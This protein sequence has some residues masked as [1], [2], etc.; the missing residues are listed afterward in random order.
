MKKI[1]I[2][3]IPLML[4]L[5]A[6]RKY[7]NKQP[8]ASLQVPN[9]LAGYRSMLDL[10][11]NTQACT[12]GLGPIGTGDYTIAPA[13]QAG[14]E[15]ISL[16]LCTWQPSLYLGNN[17]LSWSLPYTV[18]YNCNV[19]LAGL[20]DLPGRAAF[21]AADWAEY[22]A[23]EGGAL[24]I[25]SLAF[26]YLEEAFGRPWTPEH[27][28]TDLGIPL[29]LGTDPLAIVPRSPVQ[30]VYD[31]IVA[32]LFTAA[33]LLPAALQDSNRN[34]PCRSAAY[35][36]LAK[37]WLSQQNPQMAKPAADSSLLFYHTLVDYNTVDSAAAHP[38]PRGGNA[39]VL[40]QAYAM[41]YDVQYARST[42]VDTNLYRS[43]DSDDLRKVVFFQRSGSG[44]FFKGGYT[45]L[46]YLFSGV[47][48][49]DVYLLR[50]ECNARNGDA[51]AAL[52]D[53]DTLLSYRW[54]KG[55]FQ[56]FTLTNT[57]TSQVLSLVLEHRRKE[58]L[59]REG[60]WEDLRRLNQDAATAD[61]LYRTIDHQTFV[62]YPGDARYTWLIPQA[63]IDLG[64]L[65][66]NPS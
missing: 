39:E 46:A 38:F 23:I 54:R 41:Y 63:E 1:L 22:N 15:P 18:I 35:G 47:G 8:D 51:A 11:A 13:A 48:V 36:L 55:K 57:R 14:L 34:R 30:A 58:T 17:N 66:Q 64:K 50:A 19:I 4:S 29:R 6:C 37:V 52:A 3:M 12:P 53:L 40:F 2:A 24:F 59:F 26:Y 7:L 32:D 45:G 20:P 27:S 10:D 42:M 33:R 43:Y 16:G 21:S 65:P 56:P 62:L 25:R 44:Y 60:R 31:R 49:D 9:T 5:T 61:T 28:A